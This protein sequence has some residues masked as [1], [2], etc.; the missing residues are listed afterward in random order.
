MHWHSLLCLEKS[1]D[2]AKVAGKIVACLRGE[3]ARVAKGIEAAR[4]GAAGM[5]LCNSVVEGN[6]LTGDAHLL[7]A[8][9]INYTDGLVL[10]AYINSTKFVLIF[11]L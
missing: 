9:H 11:T 5:V 4:A 1:L 8:A 7:P 2:P 6:D 3:S 10:F